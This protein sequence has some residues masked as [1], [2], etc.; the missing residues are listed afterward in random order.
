MHPTFRHALANRQDKCTN[1]FVEVINQDVFY[2]IMRILSVEFKIHI[3]WGLKYNGEKQLW[4]AQMSHTPSNHKR[5]YSLRVD[6]MPLLFLFPLSN[7][8]SEVKVCL[9][10]SSFSIL[11]LWNFST[12]FNINSIPNINWHNTSCAQ[13]ILLWTPSKHCAFNKYSAPY[14]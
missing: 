6:S 14:G 7:F 12:V 2:Q 1:I 10:T 4:S 11:I 9:Y 3:W 5:V 13:G 8:Q